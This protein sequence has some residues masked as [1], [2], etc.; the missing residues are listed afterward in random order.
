MLVISSK[1]AKKMD[2]WGS[3]AGQP[4]QIG[5]FQVKVRD[6]VSQNRMR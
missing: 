5:E 1:E 3:L 6:S 2:P 4:D